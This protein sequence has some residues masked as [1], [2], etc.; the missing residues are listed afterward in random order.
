MEIFGFNESHSKQSH[1]LKMHV[2]GANNVNV[3]FAYL[4][5]LLTTGYKCVTT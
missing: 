2:M 3:P 4:W 1:Q 5:I